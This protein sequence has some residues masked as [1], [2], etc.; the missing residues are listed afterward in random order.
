[1]WKDSSRASE[2]ADIMKL[3]SKELMSLGIVE[4][5]IPEKTPV[6]TDN[7]D[8]V[9]RE[10]EEGIVEFLKKYGKNQVKKLLLKDM[11][12]LEN[13]KHIVVWKVLLYKVKCLTSF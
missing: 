4:K 9:C 6:T 7:M 8:D 1:M 11:S 13:I 2:A 3:D 12:D 10:I 5:I